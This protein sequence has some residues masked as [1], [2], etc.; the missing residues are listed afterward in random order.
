MSAP[1]S[2]IIMAGGEGSRLGYVS[3]PLIKV[4]GKTVLEAVLEAASHLSSHVYVV[5]TPKHLDV[6]E[7]C[8]KLNAEVMIS[9][10]G[11]YVGDLRVA[12]E[13]LEQPTLVL[14]ADTPFI[15]RDLLRW[16]TDEALS[17]DAD[18]VTLV[19]DRSCFPEEL[20]RGPSPTGISLFK[21]TGGRW[22]NIVICRYPELLDVDTEVD[23]RHA[24]RICG[25]RS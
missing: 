9:S 23:L 24:L 14:P 21:S 12:L 6:I 22:R 3:K 15:T 18:V 19:C 10:L 8:G 20:R 13:I 7:F 1:R 4:C 25:G 2:V 17:I 16:F 5:T 11:N